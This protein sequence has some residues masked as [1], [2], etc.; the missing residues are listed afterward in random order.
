MKRIFFAIAIMFLGIAC[1]EAK[2]GATGDGGAVVD[3]WP[4]ESEIRLLADYP[5][6]WWKFVDPKTAPDWE[7][8][9]QTARP[10][11]GEKPTKVILS[12]RTELGV[13]SNLAP[14]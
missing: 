12:K 8:L 7:I 5:A 14:T 6:D 10:K 13:L 4:D 11:R 9:P 1:A 2:K 3:T